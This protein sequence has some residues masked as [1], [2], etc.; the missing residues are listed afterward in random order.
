MDVV[1]SINLETK[2]RHFGCK[3]VATKQ[4]VKTFAVSHLEYKVKFF[5]SEKFKSS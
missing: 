5:I 4:D 2:R 3:S 1:S